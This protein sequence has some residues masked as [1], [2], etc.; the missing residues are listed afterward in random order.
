VDNCRFLGRGS[1]DAIHL[2]KRIKLSCLAS[3]QKP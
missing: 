3:G 2:P 1:F